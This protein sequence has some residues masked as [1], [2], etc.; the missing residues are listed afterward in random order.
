MKGPIRFLLAIPAVL[1]VASSPAVLAENHEGHEETMHNGAYVRNLAFVGG[2]AVDLAGAIPESAYGWRPME[3]VRS[4]SEAIM[5]MASANYFFAGRLGAAT[6]EGIDPQSM[7]EIT[8]KADCV[9]ALEKSL[10]HLSKALAAA[11]DPSAPLELFG[12]Q[13]TME[14]LMQIAVGHVHE[15]FGQLIAYA[16]SNQVVP[17]WSQSEG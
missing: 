6:P 12:R 3:G 9:A 8:A 2:R 1:L 7:E 14:D 16:R 11:S 13:M 10:D 5:H 17:P 15:H 4:V